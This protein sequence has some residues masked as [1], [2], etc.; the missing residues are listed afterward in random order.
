MENNFG[1]NINGLTHCELNCIKLK[2]KDLP[3]R[4]GFQKGIFGKKAKLFSGIN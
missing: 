1:S 3:L 4:F 2:T